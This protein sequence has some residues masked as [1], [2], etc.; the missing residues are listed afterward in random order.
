MLTWVPVTSWGGSVYTV[1][2]HKAGEVFTE[3]TCKHVHHLVSFTSR[4]LFS[5][6]WFCLHCCHRAGWQ[7]R[8]S[9][10]IR[11]RPVS[12]FMLGLAN[13]NTFYRVT[14][15]GGSVYTVATGAAASAATGDNGDGALSTSANPV[16]LVTAFGTII[17]GAL[18]GALI[19]I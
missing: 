14:S 9:R 3:V 13:S 2:T 19:T 15:F 7:G 8:H 1:A 17:G 12:S 6:R 10:N 18:L 11:R 5:C 16:L 4:P